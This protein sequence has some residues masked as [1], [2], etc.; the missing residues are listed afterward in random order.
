VS[1]PIVTLVMGV[2]AGGAGGMDGQ[3]MFKVMF[4]PLPRLTLPPG[5]GNVRPLPVGAPS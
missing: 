4:V 2:L 3:V 1:E 5:T